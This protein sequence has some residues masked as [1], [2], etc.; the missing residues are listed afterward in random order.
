[1]HLPILPCQSESRGRSMPVE[2]LSV[3]LKPTSFFK[4]NPSMDVPGTADPESVP[5]FLNGCATNG[6][7]V[8]NGQ[9]IVNG[10]ACC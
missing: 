1:M 7:A 6:H 9:P 8:V 3:T 2:H 5:A 10:H 4:L